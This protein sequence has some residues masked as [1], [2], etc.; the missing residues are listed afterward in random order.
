MRKIGTV[1]FVASLFLLVTGLISNSGYAA[2]PTVNTSESI[3]ISVTVKQ[4]T[5][6][7]ITPKSLNWSDIYPGST[8]GQ[9]DL[10]LENIGSDNITYLWINST[11]PSDRPFGTGSPTEYN[12][13]N[14]LALRQEG[15]GA[16]GQISTYFFFPN[17]YEWNE[18]VRLAYANIPAGWN[19]GRFRDA[20]QEYVWTVD[21]S[22]GSDVSLC[23]DTASATKGVLRVAKTAKNRTQT[24]TTNFQNTG[25]DYT[26][27]NLTH[28][29]GN[30]EWSFT[31][32]GI[33]I[34][35]NSKEYCAAV[36]S[37]CG[38]IVFY[39]WNADMPGGAIDS[40]DNSF[41]CAYGSY[42]GANGTDP[43]APGEAVIANT[44]VKVPYG[45]TYGEVSKGY[46]TLVAANI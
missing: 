32:D 12:A 33:K 26:Y 20:S 19:F 22:Q 27:A 29:S 17:R 41:E 2:L 21:P 25:T 44:V 31:T 5:W 39:K 43:L 9:Q 8:G 4:V 3:N 36:H 38:E 1:I 23:N 28:S 10:Y 16:S 6:L 30:P 34:G 13:G 37:S 18:T 45:T 35:P 40:G 11:H 15:A 42:F 7:D 24:G 46:L 14:F